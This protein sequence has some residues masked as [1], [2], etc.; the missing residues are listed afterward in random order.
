MTTHLSS[1]TSAL[2]NAA[3]RLTP[4]GVHSNVRLGNADVFFARGQ[5]AWLFDLDDRSYVDYVLGQGPAFLGHGNERLVEAVGTAA[6]DGMVF[7]AQHP[8]EV[9]A[10]ELLLDHLA[11]AEM[12]R[13]GVSGTEVDQAAFR[14]A[15]AFTDRSLIVRFEGHYHGWLDDVLV[16][17]VDHEQTTASN[18]QLPLRADSFAILPWNDVDA[19][20]QFMTAHG[21]E[22]AAIVMEPMM[23]NAGAIEPRPGYLSAA[24]ELCDEHGSLLIFDEVITGF[25]IHPRGA[26]GKYG[27]YPDLATFGKAVAGGWPVA[28]LAGR[29]AVME[30]FAR[31]TNH[32]GTF[33]ASTM[34]MAAVATTMRL[35]AD[36]PPYESIEK[37]GL[38]VMSMIPALARD[39]GLDLHVQGVPAA[40]HVSIGG[41]DAPVHNFEELATRDLAAYATLSR[42]FFE[43]GVWTTPRGIWY[44][45]AAHGPRELDELERRLKSA[46]RAMPTL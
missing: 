1:R 20:R 14:V 40:F 41:G 45:G 25:R 43:H 6:R 18:G 8:L 10:G 30:H 4:G 23:C 24:R 17:V 5:G 38:A 37:H 22:V 31:G 46:F 34:A 42:T 11:W 13:F 36:E 32:S 26:V 3:E 2:M 7:G 16:R 15:R 28:A 35:L 21:S 29:S 12:V 27:V 19:L 9:E 39:A 33:N 44:V